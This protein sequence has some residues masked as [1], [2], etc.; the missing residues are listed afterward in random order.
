MDTAL[1]LYQTDSVLTVGQNTVFPSAQLC[2][3]NVTA[4]IQSGV[5]VACPA[6]ALLPKGVSVEFPDARYN[7]GA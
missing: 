7:Q 5:L 2:N 6:P 3:S 1:A 4:D